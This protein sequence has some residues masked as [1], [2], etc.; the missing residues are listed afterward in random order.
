[1]FRFSQRPLGPVDFII[2]GLGNPGREYEG[3]RHNAGFMALDRLAEKQGA[4]V[5][6]VKCMGVCGD[7]YLGGGRTRH[8]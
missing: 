7:C 4:Q 3:T 5:K 6:R 2:V 1:M 8:L